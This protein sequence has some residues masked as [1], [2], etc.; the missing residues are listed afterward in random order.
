MSTLMWFLVLLVAGV[1]SFFAG[2]LCAPGSARLKQLE[3]ERDQAVS[4]LDGYRDEVDQ[5]FQKTAGLFDQLTLDYRR[6]Y[7]HLASGA[8]D[9]GIRDRQGLLRAGPELGE[10]TALISASAPA[11]SALTEEPP[12][13]DESE[14]SEPGAAG[15]SVIASGPIG[16]AEWSLAEGK[17]AMQSEQ[18]AS[19]PES[20]DDAGSKPSA[21]E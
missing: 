4:E 18:A 11:R 16:D 6:L 14:G 5:H 21:R 19:V 13:A 3:D 20:D 15:E 17:R 8:R 2:R 12:A 7:E 1:V 10:L 9:L